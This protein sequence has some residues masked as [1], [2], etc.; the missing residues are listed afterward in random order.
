MTTLQLLVLKMNRLITIAVLMCCS[1][2]DK[3]QVSEDDKQRP[4]NWQSNYVFDVHFDTIADTH[5]EL[6]IKQISATAAYD[7]LI[8]QLFQLAFSGDADVYPVNYLGEM[9][10]DRKL[11]AE[12]LLALLRFIDTVSVEDLHTGMKKDTTID[13][14]FGRGDVSALSI[15][16]RI[17]KVDDQLI[18]EPYAIAIGKQV[19][20]EETGNFRGIL[21]KFFIELKPSV[22][23]KDPVFQRINVLSDSNGVYYPTTFEYYHDFEQTPF[24]DLLT[25]MPN[26][27]RNGIQ[28]HMKWLF[29]YSNQKLEIQLEPSPASS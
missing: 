27:D 22:Q 14:S 7:D 23:L 28:V 2:S 16:T 12:D 4:Q 18:F 17:G 26:P 20:E 29:D 21:N 3:S 8:D 11:N 25:S 13:L 10:R 9:D 6:K 1:C 19:F 15:F 24:Q 5:E